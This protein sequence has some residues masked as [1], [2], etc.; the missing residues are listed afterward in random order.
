MVDKLFFYD[1]EQNTQYYYQ[2][3]IDDLNKSNTLGKYIYTKN[4]YKIFLQLVLS[5]IYEKEIKLLDYDFTKD[6]IKKLGIKEED[7]QAKVHLPS[8]KDINLDNL[9]SLLFASINWRITLF[10]SGTT[11]LPKKISHN[12]SNLT[13]MV[14]ID[15]NRKENIWGFAY[16]PTHFAGLQVFF[17]AFLNLNTIV[18]LFNRPQNE[19]NNSI[20]RFKISHISATPTFYRMIL[21][22]EKQFLS[23]T[24][25]TSGGEKFDQSLKEK[26]KCTFP[27][28]KITNVY[29]STEAGTL[30][31]AKDEV[32]I[33]KEDY[34]EFV[35]IE[36]SELLIHKN[37]MG[38]STDLFLENEWYRTG[39]MVQIE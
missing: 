10:T 33:V 12:F 29:A 26:V 35:R 28:A 31:A 16:N 20:E 8:K 32:F 18:F 1:P 37:L 39:D 7:L 22:A 30:F 17:Q 15:A 13:R 21:S 25:I 6:E 14:K 4:Y 19:I 24:R 11:G 36:N 27:N 34:R 38:E 3:F 9:V 2:E 23:V 5:I